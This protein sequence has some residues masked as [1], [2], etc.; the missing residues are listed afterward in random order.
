MPPRVHDGC[1][2]AFRVTEQADRELIPKVRAE[3][4]NEQPLKVERD[5]F[6]EDFGHLGK[7]E[8]LVERSFLF[9][10]V[11]VEARGR[12][13]L[14]AMDAAKGML[15]LRNE[16]V[17]GAEEIAAEAGAETARED[18]LA[19]GLDKRTCLEEWEEIAVKD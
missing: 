1:R 7:E 3:L 9:D 8:K 14:L 19:A 2:V 16:E 18:A 17:P 10:A 15:K 12:H 11:I 13:A 4:V 5:V 6:P